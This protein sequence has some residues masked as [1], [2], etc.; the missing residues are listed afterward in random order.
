MAWFAQRSVLLAAAALWAQTEP[1]KPCPIAESFQ[2]PLRQARTAAQR[3]EFGLAVQRYREALGNCPAERSVLLELSE[4]LV[5]TKAFDEAIAAA[6]SYVD[7]EPKSLPG[8][9][10]LANAYFMAQ[11]LTDAR[12]QAEEILRMS[13][14][15]PQAMKI[16]SNAE[17]LLGDFESARTTLVTLLDKYPNDTDASYMLARMYYQEGYME[18]AVGQFQ[19]VLKLN[20]GSYKAW[21]NLGLCY[22]ALGDKETAIRHFLTAI[23]LVEKDH[24][25]YDWAY[26]N[27]SDLLFKEGDTEK[28]FAAA[29]KAANRNPYSARNFYL[30]GR[31]LEGLGKTELAVNWLQRS[32]SLDANYA[33]PHYLLARIY[34][35]L[36]QAQKAKEASE[37]FLQLKARS[38]NKKR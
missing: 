28:A 38:G 7:G 3:H 15:V 23:K 26:A 2:L 30:G 17:Y 12:S 1:D 37:T 36:G 33:E 25:E 4:A 13:P 11:R 21:D 34:H 10:A 35:R 5:A 9:L 24:P 32:A 19:R 16:K 31:A 22:Q 6:K 27:L 29:S 20:P 18:Q 14:A 8:R